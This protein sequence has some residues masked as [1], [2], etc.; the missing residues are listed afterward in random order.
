M[1]FLLERLLKNHEQ[2]NYIFVLVVVEL[3]AKILNRKE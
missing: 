3:T 2:N 1:F